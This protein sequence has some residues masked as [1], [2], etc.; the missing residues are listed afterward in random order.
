MLVKR[1]SRTAC[2]KRNGK[3]ISSPADFFFFRKLLIFS[4]TGGIIL[5]ANDVHW[6]LDVLTKLIKKLDFAFRYGV[7]SLIFDRY[8]YF[9]TL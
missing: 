5:I 4:K 1:L 8:N 2:N 9:C 3:E 7:Y 6:F